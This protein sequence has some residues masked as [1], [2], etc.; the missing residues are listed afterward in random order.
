M[1][2][3]EADTLVGAAVFAAHEIGL[4]DAPDLPIPALAARLGVGPRRLRALVAV[5]RARGW[6]D[7]IPPRPAPPPTRP[8]SEIGPEPIVRP[9]SPT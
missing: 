3:R 8:G 6:P 5:I 4:F 1:F 2:A 7:A 9:P